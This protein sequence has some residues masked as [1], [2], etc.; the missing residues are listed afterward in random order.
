MLWM[1]GLGCLLAGAVIGAILFKLLK[2]DEARVQH[3]E[4]Q[5]QQ[6]S[7]EYENYKKEVHGHFSDSAI[8]IG[9]LTESYKD[10]YQHLAHG[11]RNLCPD[12]IATQLT[13][14]APPTSMDIS[15]TDSALA[16]DAT[17]LSPPLDYA[18]PRK[19][20]PASSPGLLGRT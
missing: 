2:S 12:Y 15:G 14:A 9:K 13:Q 3:L 16:R 17:L 1:V 11:A 20:E 6:V 8:L 18:S 10:V 19:E 5:L 7:D 4:S